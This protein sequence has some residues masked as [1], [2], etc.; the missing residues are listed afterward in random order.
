MKIP[1]LLALGCNIATASDCLQVDRLQVQAGDLAAKLPA[2]AGLPAGAVLG[3]TPAPGLRR[4]WSASQLNAMLARH[5]APVL[6][7]TAQPPVTVCVERPSRTYTAQE[8]VQALRAALPP[9]ARFELIDFCR[10]PM[11]TGELHFE[12]KSLARPAVQSTRESLLW[13]GHVR[14][15]AHRSAPF[16]A[17]VRVSVP[18]EGFYAAADLPQGHVITPADIRH[19]TRLASPHDPKPATEEADLIG[20]VCRRTIRSGIPLRGDLLARP[21]AVA[22]GDD[23]QVIVESGSAQVKFQGRA[24]ATGRQG[25]SILVENTQTG[26]RLKAFIE[27]PGQAI[28]RISDNND[29]QN[30]D[31]TGIHAGSLRRPAVA[32]GAKAKETGTELARQIPSGR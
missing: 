23:L 14:Y 11:P 31:R 32:R 18:H 4:F 3:Y 13:K 27:A 8:V 2:F 29:N 17:N 5:G 15:D 28:I 26:K 20:L 24:L 16:W 1:L 12:L 6:P 22:I 30:P 25:E 9:E 7:L 10:L 19:D 21:S